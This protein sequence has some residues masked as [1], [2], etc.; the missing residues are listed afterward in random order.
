MECCDGL[1]GPP[2]AIHAIFPDTVLQT[3]VVHVIRNATRFMS[4]GRSDKRCQGDERNSTA[5][6]HEAAEQGQ[7]KFGK[8]F[9]VQHPC[10]VDAWR[11]CW[12]EFIPFL[13]NPPEP[14][15]LCTTNSNR[16]H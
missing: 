6:T 14:P 16:V 5:L 4:A 1:T 8:K 11:N 12:G 7:A 10:A 13:D 9:G 2:D 15:R 3:Y